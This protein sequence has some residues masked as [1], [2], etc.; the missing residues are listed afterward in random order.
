[1][2]FVGISNAFS[3]SVVFPF[4][5]CHFLG[6]GPH[7]C[8][9]A[10]HGPMQSRRTCASCIGRARA[11]REGAQAPHTRVGLGLGFGPSNC[12][13]GHSRILARALTHG[14]GALM[15]HTG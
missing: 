8:G 4:F 11:R 13:N 1:M 15:K 7:P 3:W 5:P 6:T 10:G 12:W 2:Y 9:H 14:H